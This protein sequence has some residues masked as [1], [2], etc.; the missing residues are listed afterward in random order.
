MSLDERN[1]SVPAQADDRTSECISK[2]AM[3]KK[4]VIKEEAEVKRIDL[5]RSPN[6]KETE[7][8]RMENDRS[9][10]SCAYYVHVPS[11]HDQQKEQNTAAADGGVRVLERRETD[12]ILGRGKHAQLR[13]GNKAF[14]DMVHTFLPEYK[15]CTRKMSKKVVICK[16]LAIAREK[17]IRFLNQD[18][19]EA[20][21]HTVRVRIGQAFR[22]M[23]KNERQKLKL[24]MV[25]ATNDRESMSDGWTQAKPSS[26]KLID[27]KEGAS[28][29]E[30]SVITPPLQ[31]QP[32]GITNGQEKKQ[33]S[34]PPSASTRWTQQS[35]M[36]IPANTLTYL[37]AI[38]N[39]VPVPSLVDTLP[40]RSPQ[41]AQALDRY[42][43]DSSLRSQLT[44]T[45]TVSHSME[46]IRR[47]SRSSMTRTF[48]R[49]V[50]VA[51]G[52]RK[53]PMTV[54]ANSS[55][56]DTQPQLMKLPAAQPAETYADTSPS[57]DSILRMTVRD[58]ATLYSQD[59]S[60][61]SI[62]WM[63]ALDKIVAVGTTIAT[64]T[65][66]ATAANTV[67]TSSTSSSVPSTVGPENQSTELVDSQKE[68]SAQMSES[69]S[70]TGDT[71]FAET[72]LSLS[73]S[74]QG[75]NLQ[76]R[77]P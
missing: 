75:P 42:T 59:R 76:G 18:N 72:L 58:L 38:R 30:T 14:L 60:Q 17:N 55:S 13:P 28:V 34:F 68:R 11:E 3:E 67:S 49:S 33:G 37:E 57:S 39:K 47:R 66:A 56:N 32:Q 7:S 70:M 4:P 15:A 12:V 54:S 25:S 43:N 5:I 50:A 63:Q 19:T 36:V 46:A 45:A 23:I 29:E 73:R 74:F 21:E 35:K 40:G 41:R 65:A 22:Y 16:V 71:A 62:A 9:N 48:P 52:M 64:E 69:S 51:R 24:S 27:S 2:P 77:N 26:N 61:F 1:R 8:S 44:T 31:L 6:P 53:L 20:T 10:T